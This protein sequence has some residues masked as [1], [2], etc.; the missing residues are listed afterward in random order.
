MNKCQRCG[1]HEINTRPIR[2]CAVC[3]KLTCRFCFC[4]DKDGNIRC[5]DDKNKMLPLKRS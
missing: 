4:M 1:E 2:Q 3:G 5:L